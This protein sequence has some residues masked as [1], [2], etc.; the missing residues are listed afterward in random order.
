[1][2]FYMILC[3][4]LLGAFF[5]AFRI[6]IADFRRRIIP[7]IYLFPL[8][9]IGLVVVNFFPWVC[10]PAESAIGAIFGYFLAIVTGGVFER[11]KRNKNETPIGMGDVKLMATGGIWLGTT[12]IAISL[13]FACVFGMI[14]GGKNKQRYIPFAPFFVCG[15]FLSFFI[16]RF[17]L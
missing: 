14:W 12:G 15:C 17:L 16:M 2:F 4:L 6:S 11:L 3:L 8:L 1:M 5:C 13:I 7:D 9:L 10:T